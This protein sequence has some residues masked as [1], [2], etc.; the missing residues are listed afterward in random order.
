MATVPQKLFKGWVPYALGAVLVAQLAGLG[1]WQISR[2]QDKRAVQ[3]AFDR[4]TGLTR[5][6][7]GMDVEPHQRLSAEGTFDAAHQFLLDNIVVDGRNGHY[8]LTPLAYSDDEPL[9]I[10]NRGWVA[11]TGEDVEPSALALPDGRL[12]ISGRAGALPRAGY[13][14]GAAIEFPS[15]W[16]QHAVFPTLDELAAS[17]GREV[18]PF[19]LLLD[20]GG[21]YGLLRRWEPTEM[22]PGR[23]YAYAFQWFAMAAVLAGLLAWNFR[24]RG[25]GQ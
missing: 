24:K 11:A 13:R 16:P 25:H 19:V 3:E 2:G 1:V 6:V 4:Q 12:T 22:G 23:H 21:D 15:T 20:P 5:F 18:Q 7:H 17:L 9:L 14:M 8:V 10:V